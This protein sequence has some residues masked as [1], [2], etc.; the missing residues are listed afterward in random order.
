MDDFLPGPA[1][2]AH[3]RDQQNQPVAPS[4]DD[5]RWDQAVLVHYDVHR[6]PT[7]VININLMLALAAASTVDSET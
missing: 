5:V 6:A 2:L 3:L 7:R 1:F 4:A